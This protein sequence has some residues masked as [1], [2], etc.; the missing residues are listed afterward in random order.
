[1][2][3]ISKKIYTK[4]LTH[5]KFTYSEQIVT[6]L[7]LN[8]KASTDIFIG[9]QNIEHIKSNHPHDYHYYGCFLEE[10][11]Q[12]PDYVGFSKK[13]NSIEYIKNVSID[14]YVNILIAVRVSGTGRCFVK[15]LYNVSSE[16]IQRRLVK[17]TLYDLTLNED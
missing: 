16:S 10:I 7:N 6:L 3:K 1:M 15:T 13:N 12:F 2:I 17:E 4:L 14:P 9:S 5:P 8:I 11:I